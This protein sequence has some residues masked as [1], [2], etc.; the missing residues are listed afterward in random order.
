MKR[1]FLFILFITLLVPSVAS[2]LVRLKNVTQSGKGDTGSITIEL[3]AAYDASD[4]KVEYYA[5]HVSLV[6]RDAY[7]TPPS[8]RIF[9]S[10][11]PKSSV[12]RMEAS[13]IPISKKNSATVRLNIYF[14]I[15]IDI[16]KKTGTFLTNGNFIKYNYKIVAPEITVTEASVATEVS[17]SKEGIEKISTGTVHDEKLV[18]DNEL[19]SEADK[20]ESVIKSDD[21][22]KVDR[23]MRTSTLLFRALKIVAILLAILVF[24]YIAVFFFKKYFQTK[25]RIYTAPNRPYSSTIKNNY[26]NTSSNAPNN[27]PK[28]TSYDPVG[29]VFSKDIKLISTSELE[30][31]KKLYLVEVDGERLLI[32]ASKDSLS[33]VAKLAKTDK[34]SSMMTEE[35]ETAMKI[36]LKEK[37]RNF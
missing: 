27:T 18:N 12:L 11:S 15:P 16:V 13:M 20:S 8:K 9:K 2:A 14:R 34:S 33:M 29:D 28:N 35:Q 30:E 6:L 23:G 37:L 10:S 21:L 5:D 22:I 7:T 24:L 36:R 31:G 17:S 26:N 1:H 4:I 19:K 25:P 3:T 32:G